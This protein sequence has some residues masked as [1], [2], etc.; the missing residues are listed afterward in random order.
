MYDEQIPLEPATSYDPV[1]AY[2]APSAP[3]LG[4]S[5]V[6]T[7]L[8]EFVIAVTHRSEPVLIGGETGTGKE[9]VARRIHAMSTRNVQE[10]HRIDL[11][12]L[13]EQKAVEQLFDP[14]SG[15]APGGLLRRPGGT[16]YIASIE[17]CLPGTEANLIEFL[18]RD[19]SGPRLI[20]GSRFSYASLYEA[21]FVDARIL[22]ATRA[23][24]HW[25]P[26]LREHLEDLP[27]LCHY[28]VWSRTRIEEFDRVWDAFQSER[29]PRLHEYSWPGNLRELEQIVQEFVDEKCRIDSDDAALARFREQISR[30]E[31]EWLARI[32]A[33]EI[34]DLAF[35]PL[36]PD[37]NER[38]LG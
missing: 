23:F 12:D 32:D 36:L 2:D 10:F 34:D 27:A 24:V 11:S 6:A 22:D 25:I 37:S 29:L 4:P 31:R 28:Q 38:P 9:L 3:I 30:L 18:E 8:R 13:S 19:P 26:P 17:S 20:F 21:N 7:R 33:A 5:T 16:V 14:P 15:L 1:A 35:G